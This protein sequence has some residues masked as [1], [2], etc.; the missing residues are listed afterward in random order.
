MVIFL[1]ILKYMFNILFTFVLNKTCLPN[2]TGVL[3][4][5]ENF[6]NMHNSTELFLE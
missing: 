4:T 2:L 5:Y 1:K 6:S 3:E